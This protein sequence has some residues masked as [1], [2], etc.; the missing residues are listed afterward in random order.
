MALTNVSAQNVLNLLLLEATLDDKASATVDGTR[1]TQLSEQELGNVLIGT[2]HALADLGNVGEDGL[3][4]TFTQTLGRRDLVALHSTATKVGVAIRKHGEET[5]EQALVVDRL[6]LV[7][8]PDAGTLNEVALLQTAL[9]LRG[10]LLG[11]VVCQDLLLV[12]ARGCELGLKVVDGG[13][14]ALF[15]LLLERA[16]VDLAVIALGSLAL[17]V[18]LLALF[19]LLL[20]AE[21]KGGE[22]VGGLF[23]GAVRL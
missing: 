10:L 11:G 14:L 19:L 1:G 2:L 7:V 13:L 5:A 23:D 12:T 16:Q 18:L 22:V 6:C 4:V 15:L 17:I 9:G 3:L 20:C 21:R 8:C